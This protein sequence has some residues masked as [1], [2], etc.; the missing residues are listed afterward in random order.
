CTL[1]LRDYERENTHE[2]WADLEGEGDLAIGHNGKLFLLLTISG[3]TSSASISDLITYKENPNEIRTIKD[4]YKLIRS[5]HNLRDVGVLI[6]KVFKAQGLAAA[7]FGV[8]KS[9]PFCVLELINSRLQTQT[10]YKTLSP[11]WNKIFT[12]YALKDKKLRLRAK[13]NH[14][15]ILLECSVYWNQVRAA[16]QTIEPKEEKYMQIEPKFK[17]QIFV[18]NVNRVKAAIMDIYDFGLYVK[19]CFEWESP[20]RSIVAFVLFVIITYYFEAYMLPAFLLLLFVKNYIVISIVGS[21]YPKD[22]DAESSANEDEIDE[23]D[24]D[25]DPADHH[26]IPEEKKSLKERLQAIQEV[27][28]TVQNAIGYIASISESIK[29]TFNFTVPFLSWLM[30]VALVLGMA[31]LYFI[32]IRFLVLLWGINKFSR[33]LIRP[34][35]VVNNELTD[36]LSR[37][38]DDEELK[39]FREI[40][41]T[42][43]Q[44]HDDRKKR[45][46]EE[47]I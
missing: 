34:H 27:I 21:R 22:E 8:G 3:T 19:S 37:V 14:P 30:V 7:D 28:A 12:L 20:F 29:N 24:K 23:D 44:T 4:R 11:S 6:V 17:R 15:E 47:K 35:S 38:P 13:G 42:N 36:F 16:I 9:D 43:L 18:R 25:K 26:D 2:V 31:V 5:F 46:E 40:R 33:K 10:E 39:D 32:P 45:R 1:D 41:P